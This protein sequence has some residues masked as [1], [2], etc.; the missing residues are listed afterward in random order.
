MCF[1]AA[2]GVCSAGGATGFM[3]PSMH[4]ANATPMNSRT[5]DTFKALPICTRNWVSVLLLELRFQSL[6][7][8]ARKLTR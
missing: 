2:T 8:G 1:A 6:R 3:H 4:D 5:M 7:L